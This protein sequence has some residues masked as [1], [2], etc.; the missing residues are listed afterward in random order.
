MKQTLEA[1]AD[2]YQNGYLDEEFHVNDGTKAA[3]D[4]VNDKC[5][6]LYGWH[7]TALWPLQDNLNQNPDADWRPYQIV[8]SEE[9]AEVTPG[10]NMMTSSWYAVSS[11]CEHPEALVELLNLY[12]EKVFDPEL[13]EYSYYANPGDGLEGVWR[14]SPVS[15]KQP[16]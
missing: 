12:C 3:E 10:I 13:N 11:E 15:L 1:L 16:R 5:G 9:S 14:L 2:L 7:A 6:V 4:L 8:T